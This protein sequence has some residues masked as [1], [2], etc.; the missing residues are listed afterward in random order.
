MEL[1][2]DDI[3]NIQANDDTDTL[4]HKLSSI[5]IKEIQSNAV[6]PSLTRALFKMYGLKVM[7]TVLIVCFQ[8]CI[9]R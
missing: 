9:L 6:S 5:W 3:P 8:Q 7:V 2:Q 1:S 4:V